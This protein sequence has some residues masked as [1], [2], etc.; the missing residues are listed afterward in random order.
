MI[1]YDEKIKSSNIRGIAW[2]KGIGYVEFHGGRRFAYTMS[3]AL[4]ND[5]K[6]AP[7][8]GTFFSKNVKGKCPVS[9]DGYCCDNSP[10]KRDATV[11]AGA[12]TIA[13]RICEECSK[14]PRFKD[15]LFTPIQQGGR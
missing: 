7:S 4:F 12:A 14:D 3:L 13:F 8:I 6:A 5:M 10:C 1:V 11:G 15:I 2:A 9:W